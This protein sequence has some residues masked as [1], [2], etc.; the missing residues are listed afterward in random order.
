MKKLSLVILFLI[1]VTNSIYAQRDIQPKVYLGAKGGVTISKMNFSPSIP[2]GMTMGA[3]GGFVFRYAEEKH[4][5]VI[6]ELNIQQRG[7]KEDFEETS[8]SYKRTLTYI[9]IP[10]MTHIFFG[11]D[12]IKGF[13][14]L[15]PEISFMIADSYDSNFDISKAESIKDFPYGHHTEQ[16]TLPIHSKF[17]YGISA[18]LGMEYFVNKKHSVFLEGRFYYGLGN[19]FSSHKTDIF[20]ASPGMSITVNLGYFFKLK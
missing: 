13:F 17:D 8:Y 10:I 19:I 7:W 11:S 4:F 18:G 16:Y 1:C 2:Q 6:A 20:S 3:I 5:G 9:Q 14:N 12:K 15:G